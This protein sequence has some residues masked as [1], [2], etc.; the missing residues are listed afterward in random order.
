LGGRILV[1]RSVDEANFNAQAK[2]AQNILRYWSSAHYR[3]SGLVFSSPAQAVVDN[4]NVDI[5]RIR[6]NRLWRIALLATYMGGWR[7]IFY[8]GLHHR[9]DWLALKVRSVMGR[10]IPVIATMEGLLGEAGDD[11]RERRFAAI[12]GHQVYCQ[13]VPGPVLRRMEALHEMADHIIA[14]SPFLARLATARYGKKVSMLPLGVEIALFK[15]ARNARGGRPRVVGAGAARAHKRPEFFIKLARTFPQADF[16]W[17]GEGNLRRALRAE[18][19]DLGLSNVELPGAVPP[20]T[21]AR[22][23]AASDIFVLPSRNEGVPKVTQE[24]AAAG[25]AQIIFGFYEAPTVIDGHNGFVVWNDDDM[26]ARL[27]TLI[28]DPDLVGR[29][30]RAGA[31]MA[32]AWSW[33]IVAPQWERRIIDVLEGRSVVET[34]A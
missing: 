14:I 30:G 3:P 15:R 12:A 26:I 28:D 2:N 31:E 1:A 27:G 11:A 19:G 25:L 5:V 9:A 16:V 13:K 6:S 24:A 7:G 23:F 10:R 34:A 29:M 33:D 17:F 8:P 21:L 32:A 22:E 20:S 4:P 18:I